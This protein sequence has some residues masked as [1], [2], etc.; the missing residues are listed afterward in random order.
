[1]TYNKIHI[2]PISPEPTT[3]SVL[4]IYTGGTLGMVYERKGNQLVP[5]DFQQII[6]KVPEIGR[7]DFDIT[8]LSLSEPIDSSNMNP[9]IWLE[10]AGIIETHYDQYD[11]FVI[12]HGT[13]TMAYT[14]S[15]LSY[16]LENL[17]KPVI[18]T[19][20]QLPIGVARSDA[21]ENVITALELA[22]AKNEAGHPIITEVCIY[23][24]SFLLRGNRS[25]KKES[26]DFNAFHSENYPPLATAGVR[27]EY[28]LPYIKPFQEA[29]N[30]KVHKAFDNQVA[31]IKMFP[32]IS[33][34]V[35]ESILNISGLKGV[36]LETYGAGNATTETWFL[37]AISSAIEKDIIIYNVSQ[38]DG[39]RVSQGQYQ[40][41]KFLKQV[42]VV[43]G[44]DITAE[45]AI[46]KMMYIFGKESD[47]QKCIEMLARP[48]RGEMS[49]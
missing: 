29:Q 12:L 35:V 13:D 22:A 9:E 6:E 23:F 20:A 30:L 40:T 37:N 10:L 41:S 38:C 14:A 26:S 48:I 33:Q 21:R 34:Q 24:N 8:F 1:M 43:S 5:F 15:A 28:N 27:I 3:G 2:N 7:L 47:P 44:S 16:L 18:L 31:F 42:G 19:G 25:K 39:G 46:T 11:S 45:A 4:V 49:V 17:N 36:V 32:G